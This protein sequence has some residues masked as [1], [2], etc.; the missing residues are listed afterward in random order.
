MARETVPIPKVAWGKPTLQG[1]Q[2]FLENPAE[3][4]RQK[5]AT[6][7]DKGMRNIVVP[8]HNDMTDFATMSTYKDLGYTLTDKTH[9]FVASISDAQ[10]QK[11][12]KDRQQADIKQA[13]VHVKDPDFDRDEDQVLAPVSANEIL[14]GG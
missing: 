11:N 10:Y 13:R 9:F 6:V 5:E 1:K 12:L 14:A 2:T 7:D 8:L 4:L 3:Y